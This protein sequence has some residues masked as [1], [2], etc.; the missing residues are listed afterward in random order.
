M[1][2][3]QLAR[4]RVAETKPRTAPP[5]ILLPLGEYGVMARLPLLELPLA[6]SLML[7]WMLTGPRKVVRVLSQFSTQWSSVA[8]GL[9]I[10][11]DGDDAQDDR[12]QRNRCLR[13]SV[14]GSLLR[15]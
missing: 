7:S 2:R 14:H 8:A 5:G 4:T 3:F 15:A 6:S 10:V 11:G 9:C 13:A 1:T 12:G